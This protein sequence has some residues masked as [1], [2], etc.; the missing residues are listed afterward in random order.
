MNFIEERVKYLPFRERIISAEEAASYI[1][2]GTTIAIP[3]FGSFYNPMAICDAITERVK[4]KGEKLRLSLIKTAN[5]NPR[6]E[7]EWSEQGIMVRRMTFMQNNTV[8]DKINSNDGINFMDYHL[9][10]IPEKLRHGQFGSLDYA[11]I[12]CAG[13][14]EDGKL[15]PTFDQGYTPVALQAA[16]KVLIEISINAPTNLY[17]YHDVYV[18][19][20]LPNTRSSFPIDDITERIGEH[21]YSVDPD[22][23]VGIV[24]SDTPMSIMPMWNVAQPSEELT[25]VANHFADFMEAEVEAGRIPTDLLPLQTG[26]GRLADAALEELT[27][28]F[29]KLNMYTE[30]FQGCAAKLFLEGKID[31]VST[32]SFSLNESFLNELAENVDAY[33]ERLVIRPTE[34]SNNPDIISR[35]GII[36]MNNA[37]EV[38]IYGNV[39]STNAMGTR[40]IS[41]IGGSGDF[42]R[43]AYLTVFFTLST[44]K[45]GHISSIVPMCSH[46]D[47]TE[48]DVDVVVTEFGVADLRNKSPR[49]RAIELIRISHP[50]YRDMLQDYYERAV[51]EC[52]PGNCHTP[53]I[54]REAL[55]WHDRYLRTGSMRLDNI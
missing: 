12:A 13:V 2:D 6:L 16:K 15:I 27:K 50:Y 28:R 9:S 37:L 42:A 24:I 51:K 17:K 25:A 30:G 53:H 5:A 20:P 47:H 32:G 39:N 11:I 1:E 21:F 19:D 36:A 54:L 18:R 45:D 14:T 29:S 8:R 31:K 43:N 44:A 4:V 34:I 3:D 35:L 38:D 23:I 22:K 41:G 52:G 26:A 46:V 48:H 10:R 7:E 49:E 40:M 55:S 33:S